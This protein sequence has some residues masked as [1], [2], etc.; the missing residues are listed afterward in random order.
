MHF[1]QPPGTPYQSDFYS[2][3]QITAVA[4]Y[5]PQAD[6]A[7]T[8]FAL[9][10]T[11]HHTWFDVREV[12][13][14]IIEEMQNQ[15]VAQHIQIKIYLEDDTRIFSSYSAAYALFKNIINNVVACRAHHGPEVYIHINILVEEDMLM[16]DIED[17]GIGT[18]P[19]SLEP[20]V[21]LYHTSRCQQWEREVTVVQG[22]MPTL[23]AQL[24]IQSI[25]NCFFKCTICFPIHA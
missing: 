7:F 4:D 17:N 14:H 11:Q 13:S 6:T 2:Y 23:D 18:L 15:I 1:D 16:V 12:I 25:D 19:T 22:Y 8:D 10:T 20:W 5:V 21:A 3:A 9:L 24:F